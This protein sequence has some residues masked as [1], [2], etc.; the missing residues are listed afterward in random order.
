M[1]FLDPVYSPK[2]Y[3]KF[4]KCQQVHK[5]NLIGKVLFASLNSKLDC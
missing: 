1:D 4:K 2:I 5:E 3:L